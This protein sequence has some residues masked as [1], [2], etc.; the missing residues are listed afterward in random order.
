M[1]SLAPLDERQTDMVPGTGGECTGAIYYI[2]IA[3]PSTDADMPIGFREFGR[4]S[5]PL[6]PG[7]IGIR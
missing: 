7:L 5:E 3:H 4:C 6:E 2:A 1:D